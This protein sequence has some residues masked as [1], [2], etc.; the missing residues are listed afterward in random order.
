VDSATGRNP[1]AV[2]GGR[3][4]TA[5]GL[6]LGLCAIIATSVKLRLFNIEQFP[7]HFLTRAGSPS[8]TVQQIKG[9]RGNP[10]ILCKITFHELRVPRAGLRGRGGAVGGA[11]RYNVRARKN[12]R[13]ESAEP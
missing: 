1:K 12:T 9:V 3:I 13:L 11:F 5:S 4:A 10:F 6:L 2:A 8:W 7:A